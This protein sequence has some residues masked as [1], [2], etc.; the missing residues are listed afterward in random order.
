M[1]KVKQGVVAALSVVLLGGCTTYRG[2]PSH[3]GG[4]RFDEEQR[5]VAAS[6]AQAVD[7]LDFTAYKGKRVQFV[8]SELETS[9]AGYTEEAGL[10][11]ISPGPVLWGYKD[12]LNIVYSG[13]TGNPRTDK[14]KSEKVSAEVK[15]RTKPIYKPEKQLSGK[16]V[17]YLEQVLEMKATFAGVKVVARRPDIL[18]YILVDVLGT[19]RSTLDSLIYVKEELRAACD[20][21][22]YVANG[23]SLDIIQEPMQVS[24]SAEYRE[25]KILF[26][27]INKVSY[28]QGS[29]KVLDYD[30]PS[31]MQVANSELQEESD[32]VLAME[33][34]V[35]KVSD[36]DLY[37]E[38]MV[39]VEKDDL[40]EARKYI[41]RIKE[42]DEESSYVADL[43]EAIEEAK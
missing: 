18:V 29:R 23:K 2:V 34:V 35:K 24:G 32:A 7:Q 41:R 21:T 42:I 13:P 26:T 10:T 12:R 27:N 28:A 9:G 3:G 20:L 17:S 16:D 8:V 4:K 40:K 5:L 11:E 22:C 25:N 39:L 36:L 37:K 43:A 19:N 33:P 30:R 14:Y 6:I 15:F 31:F 38:A 1:S